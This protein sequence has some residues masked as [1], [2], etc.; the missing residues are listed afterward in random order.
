MPVSRHRQGAER[1]GAKIKDYVNLWPARFL[2]LGVRMLT[3]EPG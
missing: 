1:G 2:V 3:A